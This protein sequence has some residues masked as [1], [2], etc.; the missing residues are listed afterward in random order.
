[1]ALL[2]LHFMGLIISNHQPEVQHGVA[3]TRVPVG[4]TEVTQQRQS[5]L[6]DANM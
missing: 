1:M 5:D 4:Q 2:I 6:M 3:A